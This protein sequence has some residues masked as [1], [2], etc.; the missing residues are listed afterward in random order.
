MNEQSLVT[1]WGEE[2][3]RKRHGWTTLALGSLPKSVS[4]SYLPGTAGVDSISDPF[5]WS[6]F[7]GLGRDPDAWLPGELST[8]PSARLTFSVPEKTTKAPGKMPKSTKK[9]VTKH[10]KRPTT[11]APVMPTAKH[12]RVPGTQGPPELTSR[13]TAVLTTEARH[14]LTSHTTT[15]P[16][17]WTPSTTVTMTT[18]QDPREMTSEATTIRRSPPSSAESSAEIPAEGS[19]ESSKDPVPSPSGG[20]PGGSGEWRA[21]GAR[22]T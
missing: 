13:T 15:A 10:A 6:W 2:D 11:Q 20:T 18:T 19:P 21:Q 9:W 5:S 12:S 1:D 17:P 8:K 4:C 16:T 14:R 22:L 7:P 3:E